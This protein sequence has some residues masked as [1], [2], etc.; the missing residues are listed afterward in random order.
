LQ[1]LPYA[2]QLAY[3]T[4]QVQD[5]LGRIGKLPEVPVTAM[6][7]SPQP[8]H[9]RNKVLYHY[10]AARGA[11]GL[12]ARHKAQILDIPHCLLNDPRADAVLARVRTLAATHP[13]LHRVLHQVQV[14][15]SQRTGEVLVTLLVRATL[16]IALQRQLWDSLHDLVTGLFLHVKTRQ[17]PELFDGT[18]SHIAGSQ[19]MHERVGPWLF[20]IEPQAFF[21][22]N[23]VQMEY[24]YALVQDAAA[25]QGHE[26]VFDLYSGG[27]TIALSLAPHCQTVYGVEV[28]RQAT[29]LAMQQAAALG[30][31]NCQFR[32]GK[33]ERIVQRYLAE[34]IRANVAVLDPPRAGCDPRA[35]DAPARKR[36]AR[37]ASGPRAHAC[38]A[39]GVCFL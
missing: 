19:A 6:R 7:E 8:F 4:A 22:V 37:R 26:I 34:G 10:D 18:T 12:V 2:R 5:A 1:H 11:L 36:V 33:V 16:A 17:T 28:Q 15:L 35:R 31:S 13:A 20:R 30:V 24:L 25:L 39:S 38:A 23:T 27:G 32:T 3:K 9:Y 14:Q 21:Q 29:L